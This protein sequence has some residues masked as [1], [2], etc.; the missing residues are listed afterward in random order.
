M[1][2]VFI[3]ISSYVSMKSLFI[4]LAVFQVLITL[5]AITHI[6]EEIKVRILYTLN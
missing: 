1:L 5:R 4:S 3:G 6:Y 2:T